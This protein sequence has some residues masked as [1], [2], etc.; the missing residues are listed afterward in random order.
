MKRIILTIVWGLLTGWA[1]VPCL[2][3]QSRTGTAD[4]EIWVKTLVRLAD[5]L[6]SNLANEKQK[7]E[8]NVPRWSKP[9]YTN[10]TTEEEKEILDKQK[11]EILA[12]FAPWLEL[13][14]DET[15]E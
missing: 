1:A 2:W 10:T 11:K 7:K 15:R 5:P 4:R 8:T 6:L 3:A 14:E 9:N 12:Q 13:G